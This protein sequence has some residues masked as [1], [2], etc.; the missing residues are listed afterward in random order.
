M[1]D[2]VVGDY[3]LDDGLAGLKAAADQV[4]VCSAEPTSYNEAVL[5]SGGYALGHKD[6]GAGNVFGSIEAVSPTGRALTSVSFSGGIVDAEGDA[7]HWAIV[8]S[9]GGG[10]LLARGPL[11]STKALV[12]GQT[13]SLP[14]M[15]ISALGVGL[16]P[17]FLWNPSDKDQYITLS[18]DDKIATNAYTDY[19]YQSNVRGVVSRSSGK[20]YLKFRPITVYSGW[21]AVGFANSSYSLTGSTSSSKNGLAWMESGALQCGADSLSGGSSYVDGDELELALDLDNSKHWLRK[22]VGNWN[23][24]TDD[25]VTGTFSFTPWTAYGL[26][27]GPYFPMFWSGRQTCSVEIIAGIPPDGFSVW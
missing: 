25:P 6:L 22:N 20:W 19:F 18:G 1:A 21:F 3:V 14:A 10:Q 23:G 27:A 4:Y 8:D 2:L 11:N 17:T 5:T 24:N 13:F 12:M 16:A 15:V 7:T 26:L 9:S